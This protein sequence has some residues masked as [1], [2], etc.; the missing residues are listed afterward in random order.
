[1]LLEEIAHYYIKAGKGQTTDVSDVNRCAHLG[2]K[3]SLGNA[4]NYLYYV[5]SEFP[6]FVIISGGLGGVS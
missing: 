6:L 4:S 3:K 2:I 5:A 1:M